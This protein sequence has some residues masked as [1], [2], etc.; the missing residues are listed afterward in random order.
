MR[1]DLPAHCRRLSREFRFRY[2]G[3]R[4]TQAEVAPRLE[5]QITA[6]WEA[7]VEFYASIYVLCIRA[8]SVIRSETHDN[9]SAIGMRVN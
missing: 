7:G 6:S 5:C 8:Q 1:T 2:K 4:G 9:R 3:I